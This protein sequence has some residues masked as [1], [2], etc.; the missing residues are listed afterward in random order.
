MNFLSF[1]TKSSKA[2]KQHIYTKNDDAEFEKEVCLH[3]EL[4]MTKKFQTIKKSI[5]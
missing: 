5:F 3:I 2:E 1:F 4:V